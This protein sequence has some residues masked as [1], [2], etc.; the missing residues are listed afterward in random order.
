MVLTNVKGI[1]A[2]DCKNGLAKNGIIP[3]KSKTDLKFF[4]NNTINHY[5]VMGINTLLSLPH[6]QPLHNRMNIIITNQIEK[7]STIYKDFKNIF[8]FNIEQTIQYMTTNINYT[9]FIIG[10][11]QIYNLLLPYCS[12]ILVTKIKQDYNCDLILNYNISDYEKEIIYEDN[13]LEI[14][15]LQ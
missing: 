6:S 5:V 15:R 4:R 2:I 10:G 8:F 9:F 11:N 7:Y 12:T 13:E 3:W 1:L 14:M